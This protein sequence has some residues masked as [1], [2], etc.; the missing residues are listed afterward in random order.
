MGAKEQ[1]IEQRNWLARQFENLTTYL[2]VSTPSEC[3]ERIRYLPPSNTNMPGFYRFSVAPYLREIVDCLSVDSPIREIAVMKG[4]QICMTTGV[5]ENGILYGIEHVKTAP[6]MLVTA[7][8]NLAK[9]RIDS[10]IIPMIQSSGL[11]H[12][13]TSADEGNSRKTGK[14]QQ[15]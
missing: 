3:A 8:G 10:Y 11:N 14:N 4:V 12:L 1:I 5:L 2:E 9:G 13:I 15:R 7:D 6:M